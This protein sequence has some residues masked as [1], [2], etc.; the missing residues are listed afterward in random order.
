MFVSYIFINFK[1]IHHK[2]KNVSIPE[3]ATRDVLSKKLF[4]KISQYSNFLFRK[5]PVLESPFNRFAGFK[6]FNFLKK[7]LQ[8]RKTPV[9]ESHFKKVAGLEARKSIKK[10][11]LQKFLRTLFW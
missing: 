7:G 10:R 8:H 11:I 6:N 5:T 4:L 9:L 3:A 1:V 2:L